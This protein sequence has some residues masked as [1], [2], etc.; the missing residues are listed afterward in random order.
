[1]GPMI[2][3]SDWYKYWQKKHCCGIWEMN[4]GLCVIGECSEWE[5]YE[6]LSDLPNTNT[7]GNKLELTIKIVR[8]SKPAEDYNPDPDQ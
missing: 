4:Q 5:N 1:M 2:W 3:S 8:G 7:E 6:S